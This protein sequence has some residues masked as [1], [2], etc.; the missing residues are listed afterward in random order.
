MPI[1]AA[2]PEPFECVVC[3]RACPDRW[4]DPSQVCYPPLCW[5]C[6]QYGWRQG[7]VTRNPD[8][9]LIKQI[10]VLANVLASE[11]NMKLYGRWKH[12]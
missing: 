11:A 10:A 4:C 2:K 9:R 3:G 6:E 7:P 1:Y 8:R 5:P 12:V